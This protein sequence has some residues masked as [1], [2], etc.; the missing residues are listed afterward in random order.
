MPVCGGPKKLRS[1]TA[2]NVYSHGVPKGVDHCICKL[3]LMSQTKE[4]SVGYYVNGGHGDCG[5]HVI[6][7]YTRFSCRSQ[8]HTNVSRFNDIKFSRTSESLAVMCL[9]IRSGKNRCVALKYFSIKG[10]L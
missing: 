7:G 9:E 2:I 4:V 5:L 3:T 1:F 10:S 8:H 6:L